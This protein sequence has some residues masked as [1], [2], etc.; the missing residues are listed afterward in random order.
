[1][2]LLITKYNKV[3]ESQDNI[4]CSRS[5]KIWTVRQLDK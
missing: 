2:D 4:Q 1:M 3:Q 5:E